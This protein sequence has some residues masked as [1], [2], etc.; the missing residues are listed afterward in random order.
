MLL[1]L[2][3]EPAVRRFWPQ[4]II[5]WTRLLSG[6]VND[7]LV[8]QDALYGVV[9]GLVWAVV[10][11]LAGYIV[12]TRFGIGY[13]TGDLT[14]LNGFRSALGEALAL[15]PSAI[16]ST[17]VFFGVLL[18]ARLIFRRIWIAS[19]V[20]TA[21]FTFI[22]T[23]NSTHLWFDVPTILVIYGIAAIALTRFGLVTLMVAVIAANMMLNMPMSGDLTKWYFG[24]FLVPPVLLLIFTEVETIVVI[25]AAAA[26]N[27]LVSIA[28][29]GLLP[30]A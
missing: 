5:S 19:V 28:L 26:V 22:Q 9:L 4:A 23:I 1:Y 18:V 29:S 12:I 21:I 27:L 8:G 11:R 14:V 15:I 17:F 16:T 24:T 10:E 20:F 6:K 2:S 30:P 7:P 13:N 3:V 25:A